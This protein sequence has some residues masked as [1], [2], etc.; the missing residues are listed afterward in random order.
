M[1][2]KKIEQAIRLIQ[3]AGCDGMEVEVAYSGGK[4]SD[5]ILELTRMAGIKY[6]AIYKNTTI[7]PIGTIA[8]VKANDVEI[9]RPKQ[10]FFQLIE[11]MGFPNRFRRFC[12]RYL[13]EYKVLDRCIMGVRKAESTKRAARHS[14][15]TECR[16]YGSKREHVEAFYPILDWSD[17]DIVDFIMGRG[18]KLHTL[19][20]RDD[21]SIDPK[22]RLGCMCCPLKSYRKRIEDFKRYPNMVKA[23]IRAGQ[24]FLDTHPNSRTASE[25]TNVYAWFYRDVLCRSQS[26]YDA[27]KNG[28]FGSTN[29]WQKL[30]HLLFLQRKT[31]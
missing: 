26:D 14:E 17:Q 28:L 11:Q 3:S 8:H 20:Y 31:K 25:Y 9:I 21:G 27:S 10:T 30:K 22:R 15:P 18:V 1:M 4:D 13:K 12:C 2:N 24:K 6:R 29:Y 16:F 23:Y 7:D 19:Y 5:V